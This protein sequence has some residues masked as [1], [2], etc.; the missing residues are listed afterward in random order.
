MQASRLKVTL[1]ILTKL[2]LIIPPETW[3]WERIQLS[4]SKFEFDG[5]GGGVSNWCRLGY[6]LSV[7][8]ITTDAVWIPSNWL[9]AEDIQHD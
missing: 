2:F 8:N 5:G 9:I 1:I 6:E 4:D 3:V 7:V